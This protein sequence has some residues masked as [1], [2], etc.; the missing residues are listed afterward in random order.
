MSSKVAY[1]FGAGA[2]ANA[3]P[4]VSEM[5]NGLEKFLEKIQSDSIFS[6]SHDKITIDRVVISRE[7]LKHSLCESLAWLIKGTKEHAS[8]DTYAKKLY[9][10]GGH[11]RLI[12]L[13]AALSCYFTYLQTTN[14]FDKRYDTFFASI[15]GANGDLSK[16][17]RILSWNYDSQFEIAYNGYYGPSNYNI[18]HTKL[19]I[20]PSDLQL[21]GGQ[22]IEV[23]PDEFAI[24]KLNGTAGVFN[25]TRSIMG[26]ILDAPPEL[27]TPTTTDAIIRWYGYLTLSSQTRSLMSFAWEDDKIASEVLERAQESTEDTT[28]IVCIGYSFPYFNRDI[29]RIIIGGMQKLETIYFQALPHHLEDNM[30]RFKAIRT[31]IKEVP[32]RDITQF[33]IPPEL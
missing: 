3:L 25:T 11:N 4:V 33:F 1:L 6:F 17:I 19:N 29:D 26:T 28:T 20:T 31:D 21:H 13:K 27:M 2:S 9:L 30:A 15:I 8:I 12:E 10:T 5:A 23:K 22:R 18:I 7:E 32:I 14:S 24:F 16:E